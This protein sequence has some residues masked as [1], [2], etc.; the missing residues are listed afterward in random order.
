MMGKCKL[1]SKDRG[2]NGTDDTHITA[3]GMINGDVD[4]NGN[5]LTAKDALSIQKYIAKLIDELPES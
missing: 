4:Q 5:G 1:S 3:Q 2:I